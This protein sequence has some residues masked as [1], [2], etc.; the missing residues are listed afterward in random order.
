[1]PRN[2]HICYRLLRYL[3][4]DIARRS[5]INVGWRR[6]DEHAPAYLAIAVHRQAACSIMP[7]SFVHCSR[8]HTR[9]VEASTCGVEADAHAGN[10]TCTHRRKWASKLNYRSWLDDLGAVRHRNRRVCRMKYSSLKLTRLP[11]APS[12]VEVTT[13]CR[14]KSIAVMPYATKL[15]RTSP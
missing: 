5:E 9:N 4:A 1:M 3:S 10:I 8:P 15:A 12:F 13:L 2:K 11:Q 6:A 7:P 14:P